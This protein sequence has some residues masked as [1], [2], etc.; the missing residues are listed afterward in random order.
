M[1]YLF[2]KYFITTISIILVTQIISGLHIKGDWKSLLYSSAILMILFFIGRPIANILMLPLNILTLNLSSWIL[3]ILF[4][5]IW[6][7]LVSNV[8][9]EKWSFSGANVGPLILS[10]FDFATWQVLI[11][12]AILHTTLIQL[13]DKLL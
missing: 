3:N 9:I 6:T 7:I 11:L 1:K 5:Y 12:G 13:F 10:P 8:S 4:F 2:K